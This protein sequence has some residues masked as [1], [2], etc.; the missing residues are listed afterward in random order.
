[1][2]DHLV[3]QATR[4]LIERRVTILGETHHAQCENEEAKPHVAD[5]IG[6]EGRPR[7]PSEC[8]PC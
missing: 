6:W 3:K 5:Y 4:Q 1:M 7:R 8:R 2:E